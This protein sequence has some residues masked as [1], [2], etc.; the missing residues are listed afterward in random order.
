M[1]ALF[2]RGRLAIGAV[3]MLAL[4]AGCAGDSASPEPETTTTTE[5]STTTSTVATT[6][7][8]AATSTT[9][10][11]ADIGQLEEQIRA[12]VVAGHLAFWDFLVTGDPSLV[13]P[14]VDEGL[15]DGYLANVVPDLEE[16][17]LFTPGFDM[18]VDVP[19][20]ELTDDLSAAVV[21]FC[22]VSDQDL[23]QVSEAG[24]ETVGLSANEPYGV[25]KRVALGEDGVW[26]TTF[27]TP[28]GLFGAELEEVCAK[29]LGG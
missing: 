20:V 23:V 2:G 26:K 29:F 1:S 19:V 3:L 28:R 12:D 9:V 17:G 15:Y 21:R 25:V 8:T 10:S 16:N 18:Q 24:D 4:G 5:A 27:G 11:D 14:Y 13:E 6:T 22:Y 7:S